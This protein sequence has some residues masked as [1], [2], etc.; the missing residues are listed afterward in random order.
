[1][2]NQVSGPVAA[3]PLPGRPR[4]GLDPILVVD[5]DDVA[6]AVIA[7][8]LREARLANPVVRCADGQAALDYLRSVG[9]DEEGTAFPALVL[10]DESMPRLSGFDVLRVMKA[11]PV[12]AQIPVIML[13]GT[14]GVDD[15]N[16]AYRLGALSY[17][18]KPVGFDA[19]GDVLRS[20]PLTWAF[21]RP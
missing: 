19:L 13:T 7:Q 10:L 6:A 1:V 8:L 3:R 2:R 15:V 17:L 21:Y 11:D 4:L 20:V 12:L 16:G 18:V 14:S 9:E 5:D